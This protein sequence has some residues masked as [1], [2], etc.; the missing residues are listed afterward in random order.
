MPRV[1]MTPARRVV[2]ASLLVWVVGM[3]SLVLVRFLRTAF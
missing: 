2:L 3:L 1:R